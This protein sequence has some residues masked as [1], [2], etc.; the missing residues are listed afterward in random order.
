MFDKYIYQFI[1][2]IIYYTLLIDIYNI[3]DIISQKS[4]LLYINETLHNGLRNN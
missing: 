4:D 1:Y 3:L 2:R